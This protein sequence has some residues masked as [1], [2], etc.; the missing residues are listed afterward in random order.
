MR[1]GDLARKWHADPEFAAAW[2]REEPKIRL[3]LNVLKRR[4]SLGVSQ[5][6]LARRAEVRRATLSEIENGEGNPTLETLGALAKT[7]GV[8]VSDLLANTED[9]HPK[10]ELDLVY[11]V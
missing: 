11:R 3:G 10:Q 9:P 8:N 4:T 5:A 7:L 1:W 6:E 2:A